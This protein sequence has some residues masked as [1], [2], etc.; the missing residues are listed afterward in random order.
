MPSRGADWPY[1]APDI[2]SREASWD[3][4]LFE[5]MAYDAGKSCRPRSSDYRPCL[6]EAYAGSRADGP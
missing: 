2:W 5:A 6:N 4:G 1:P 3:H